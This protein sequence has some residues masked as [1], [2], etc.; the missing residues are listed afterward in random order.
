M[1]LSSALNLDT[2]GPC[3]CLLC[4][5]TAAAGLS[6]CN[7]CQHELPRIIYACPTCAQPLP[8]S[9]P[10]PKCQQQ[11]PPIHRCIAAFHYQGAI[12]RIIHQLKYHQ[13][14]AAAELLG[15]LM[16]KSLE[17]HPQEALPQCL[18]PVPLHPKRL[19]Q[20]GYNQVVEMGRPIAR[21]F[22]LPLEL[23]LVHRTRPTESQQTLSA[24][25]RRRNVHGAFEA[26][27]KPRYEHIA[28]LDDVMT[29]GATA[30]ELAHC[31]RKAGVPHIELWV[32]ARAANAQ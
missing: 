2:L 32:C 9:Y 10:C 14:L 31:L 1:H 12:R 24:V 16:A 3:E 20:R 18:V 8:A 30:N 29:T 7:P 15:K 23:G 26:V 6:I 25:A 5:D 4:G 17:S 13:D 27:Y 28:L 22:G 19:R 21:E 11:P